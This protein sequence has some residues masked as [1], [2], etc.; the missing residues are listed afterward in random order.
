MNTV[1]ALLLIVGAGAFMLWALL[2]LL[3]AVKA[4]IARKREEKINRDHKSDG[5]GEKAE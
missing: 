3:K 2:N 5:K 4:F 1:F